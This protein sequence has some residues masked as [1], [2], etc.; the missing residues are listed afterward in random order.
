M[1]TQPE[2]LR[3][4]DALMLYKVEAK[5]EIK[6]AAELRRLYEVNAE[7]LKVC[8]EAI[9]DY[10]NADSIYDVIFGWTEMME[11]AIAKATGEQQ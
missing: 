2:A 5:E 4:A 9:N 11:K 7:L 10:K 6:A 1:T 8:Q 3:L